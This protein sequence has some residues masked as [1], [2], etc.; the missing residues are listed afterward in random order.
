MINTSGTSTLMTTTEK[1]SVA[2]VAA[3]KIIET[4]YIDRIYE[5]FKLA[6]D[7][8]LENMY[9]KGDLK[10]HWN[11]YIHGDSFSDEK[12]TESIEKSL[13]LGQIELF[14]KYLSYHDKSLMDAKMNADWVESC[15]I[16][17]SFKPLINTFGLSNKNSVDKKNGRPAVEENKI[18]NDNTAVSVDSGTNTADTKF[19]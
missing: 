10:Y 4:R 18:E 3:G 7:V 15:G 11:F 16:Y 1:P 2:Q 5:Q 19:K 17:D 6:C 12:A 14:P 9:K 13:S 8:I